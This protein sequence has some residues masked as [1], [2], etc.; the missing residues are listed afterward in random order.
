MRLDKVHAEVGLPIL[1]P[2]GYDPESV[3]EAANEDHALLE[4]MEVDLYASGSQESV[5]ADPPLA[6]PSRPPVDAHAAVPR[7]VYERLLP[8]AN[9]DER[10]AIDSRLANPDERDAIDSRLA[11]PDQRD[12]I[13]IRLIMLLSVD[14]QPQMGGVSVYQGRQ[15]AAHHV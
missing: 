3:A 8:T 5:V 9:P 14:R 4:G 12:A 13:V 1:S 15:L 2:D 10:D 7:S 11:N 6:L